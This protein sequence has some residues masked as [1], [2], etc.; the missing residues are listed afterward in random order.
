M[1]SKTLEPSAAKEQRFRRLA[2]AWK[3]ETLYLSNAAKKAVHPAYQGIIGLG[4]LA[5][6]W[7]L[8][9]L[10]KEPCDWFWA[11]SAITGE[12]PIPEES[13]GKVDEMAAAW[14]RWGRE[15]GY[16]Q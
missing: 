6:P 11:L 3:K 7:I 15:Q 1:N 13:A 12:N 14:L 5:V 8:E 16:I 9:E 4:E 10:R 2:E